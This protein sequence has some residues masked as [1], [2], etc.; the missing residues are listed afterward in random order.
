MAT[1]LT[2]WDDHEG[3]YPI[4]SLECSGK[5]LKAIYE[6][7]DTII[8]G[9]PDL[10][11][12]NCGFGPNT[13]NSDGKRFGVSFQRDP[14]FS[15]KGNAIKPKVF[16]T[17]NGVS[18]YGYTKP[19]RYADSL[20]WIIHTEE[21]GST[22]LYAPQKLETDGCRTCYGRGTKGYNITG[23]DLRSVMDNCRKEGYNKRE[24]MTFEKD[25]AEGNIHHRYREEWKQLK[26][27]W[28]YDGKNIFFLMQ[29]KPKMSYADI[30]NVIENEGGSVDA[31][32]IIHRG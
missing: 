11:I 17:K 25:V 21:D 23:K 29:E 22:W 28:E 18:L 24:V 14:R 8:D 15:P 27:S 1:K 7:T 10:G 19:L 32:G 30:V 5:Y 2:F 13:L 31:A 4:E 9:K 20:Q 16:K 26:W 12:F 3:D 6:L